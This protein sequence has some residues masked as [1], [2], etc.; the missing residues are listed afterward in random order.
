MRNVLQIGKTVG[1]TTLDLGKEVGKDYLQTRTKKVLKHVDEDSSVLLKP[2][3]IAF[4]RKS[5]PSHRIHLLNN[6]NNKNNKSRHSN[7]G[8]KTKKR[9]YKRNKTSKRSKKY[10]STKRKHNKK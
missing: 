6:K 7:F 3:F 9:K 1:K 4:G 8:G 10:V 2:E 5:P